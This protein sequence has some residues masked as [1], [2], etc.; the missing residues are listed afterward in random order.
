MNHPAEFVVTTDDEWIARVCETHL[1]AAI[2]N[3]SPIEVT[4]AT[5]NQHAGFTCDW[6]EMREWAE[7]AG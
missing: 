5:L 2:R 4:V 6:E 7:S 1:P 3:R